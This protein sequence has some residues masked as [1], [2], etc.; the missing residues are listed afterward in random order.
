MKKIHKKIKY[1]RLLIL[2]VLFAVFLAVVLHV[3]EKE[4]KSAYMIAENG[5]IADTE[6]F[7]GLFL[8]EETVVRADAAGTFS[9]WFCQGDKIADGENVGELKLLNDINTDPVEM[10]VSPAA[11]VFSLAVDGWETVL[12]ADHVKKLNLGEVFAAYEA[13]K[14]Q[15]SGFRRQGDVCYKVIDN[16]KDVYLLTALKGVCLTADTVRLNLLG[17]E[18]EADV[19]FT[20]VYG[21]DHYALLALSPSDAYF[22]SRET[23]VQL[24]LSEEEGVVI[25]ASAVTNRYG[26]TGVYCLD[27]GNLSFC[28]VTV[29]QEKDAKVLVEGIEAGSCI[30]CD[31]D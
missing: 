27:G 31:A 22:E 23:T 17:E 13:P 29:L 1:R 5:M 28:P 20:K 19:V 8:Y 18:I 26:E 2:C 25:L 12:T 11:G 9:P 6:T 30:L 24:I 3:G 14:T 7:E 4:T 10:M 15:I 21:D 16:K